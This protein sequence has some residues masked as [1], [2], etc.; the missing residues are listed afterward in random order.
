MRRSRDAAASEIE[1]RFPLR[2]HHLTWAAVSASLLALAWLIDPY[3]LA[4]ASCGT[5]A[6]SGALALAAL[7]ASPRLLPW[8]LAGALPSAA[9]I[10]LIFTYKWA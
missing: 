9:A 3:V 7:V 1:S 4:L 6:V 10:L 5:A 8:A 2:R